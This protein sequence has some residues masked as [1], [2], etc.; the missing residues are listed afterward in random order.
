MIKHQS[1]FRFSSS[2]EFEMNMCKKG[3]ICL[4]ASLCFSF[5]RLSHITMSRKIF[6]EFTVVRFI[7]IETIQLWL[8][9]SNSGRYTKMYVCFCLHVELNSPAIRAQYVSNK[10]R[11]EKRIVRFVLIILLS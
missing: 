3:C 11:R 4:A 6:T 1:Q 5:V 2:G 9:S 10:R 8:K 7:S